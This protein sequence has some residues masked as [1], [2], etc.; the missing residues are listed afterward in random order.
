MKNKNLYQ[1][2]GID[3][4]ATTEEIKKAFRIYASKFHPDKHQADKFFEDKF[5]EIKDAYDILIDPEKREGYDSE[6]IR[7]DKTQ[8]RR[9]ESKNKS[10]SSSNNV[11][12]SIKEDPIKIKRN[13]NVMIGLMTLLGAIIIFNLGGQSGWHIPIGIF[14]SFWTLR[15]AFAVATSYLKD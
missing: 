10:R 5:R 2:L 9:E 3:S 4:T 12:E 11:A 15:Q 14:L 6:W 8:S 7:G 13:K 1:V